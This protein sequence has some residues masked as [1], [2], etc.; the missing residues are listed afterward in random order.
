MR[1]V[2]KQ[3]RNVFI[4]FNDSVALIGGKENEAKIRFISFVMGK[5]DLVGWT[6]WLSA[7]LLRV[8]WESFAAWAMVVAQLLSTRLV[9]VR[10][11]VHI[12]LGADNFFTLW[13][14]TEE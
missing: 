8:D 11:W 3:Q 14:P 9:I 4:I 6:H 7:T 2:L 12:H 1:F 13:L 10:L 5:K